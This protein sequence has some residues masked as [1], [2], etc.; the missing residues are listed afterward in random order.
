[1]GRTTRLIVG[2]IIG[3]SGGF[4]VLVAVSSLGSGRAIQPNTTLGL[5]L[6]IGLM[7]SALVMVTKKSDWVNPQAQEAAPRQTIN[8]QI[9]A[10]LNSS[11]LLKPIRPQGMVPQPREIVYLQQQ[12][13][14]Y[15][16]Q[17]VMNRK[18]QHVGVSM[19]IPHMHGLRINT[20]SFASHPDYRTGFAPAGF[21]TLFL[22]DQ[23]IIWIGGMSNIVIPR[24][25]VLNIQP[26]NDGARIDVTGGK[27]VVFITGDIRFVATNAKLQDEESGAQWQVPKEEP[28]Q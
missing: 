22:T 26:Y 1:M 27:P 4:I 23:R 17:T 14:A 8:D 9:I 16:V 18:G 10:E 2:A 19:P 28:H 24:S 6:G 7:F 5:I 15:T 12:A 13:S 20:G 11:G 25:H 21:G 3:I